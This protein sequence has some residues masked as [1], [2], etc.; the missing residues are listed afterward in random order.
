MSIVLLII[1]VIILIFL[2]INFVKCLKNKITWNKL[3]IIEIFSLIYSLI[4]LIYYYFYAPLSD[5]F[6]PGLT[7]LGETLF[8]LGATILYS[9]VFAISLITK[10]ILYLREKKANWKITFLSYLW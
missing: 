6:M 2:I 1:Y 8:S 7:N 3:F 9:I 4:L 5:S 10:L